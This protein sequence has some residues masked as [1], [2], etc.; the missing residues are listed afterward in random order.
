MIHSTTLRWPDRYIIFSIVSSGL[1]LVGGKVSAS[2]LSNALAY[3]TLA[4][5]NL[6]S[7]NDIY[8]SYCG[9][10]TFECSKK[11]GIRAAV[12]KES[13]GALP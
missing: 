4:S 10:F 11:A 3:I 13:S 6:S 7:V 1:G 5:R 12:V 9:S 8:Q 2:L